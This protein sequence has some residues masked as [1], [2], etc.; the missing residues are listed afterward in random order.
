MPRSGEHLARR[1]SCGGQWRAPWRAGGGVSTPSD[2][3]GAHATDCV[4][5]AAQA[6]GP[7]PPEAGSQQR[8]GTAAPHGH[9]TAGRV[10]P[11]GAAAPAACCSPS[12]LGGPCMCPQHSTAKQ[13]GLPRRL[14]TRLGGCPRC[15][16]RQ[17]RG[18]RRRGV[19]QWSSASRAAAPGVQLCSDGGRFWGRNQGGLQWNL[20]GHQAGR[21][22][23]RAPR[24]EGGAGTSQSVSAALSSQQG[25]AG[26]HVLHAAVCAARA[27]GS[28]CAC[29]SPA[30]PPPRA[31]RPAQIAMTFKNQQVLKNCSWEVKKGERVG[32]VRPRLAG[33]RSAWV[34]G[35]PC[36]RARRRAWGVVQPGRVVQA[37]CGSRQ[38]L[39][40][41]GVRGATLLL[42]SVCVGGGGV[43]RRM[44][45]TAVRRQRD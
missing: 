9:P 8:A 40:L 34:Q 45:L 22:E 33:R 1:A 10:Q 39:P 27:A 2:C 29:A 28:A 37:V 7:A 3:M 24:N 44:C 38:A 30:P 35:P 13:G 31:C 36:P 43:H 16:G 26:V 4:A 20:I 5:N 18:G 11:A 25:M 42:P 41:T 21:G 17:S 23:A 15:A 19:P 32:L 6:A 12:V 14:L